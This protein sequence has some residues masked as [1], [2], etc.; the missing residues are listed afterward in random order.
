MS[1]PPDPSTAENPA[2]TAPGEAPGGDASPAVGPDSGDEARDRDSTWFSVLMK[3]QFS[4]AVLLVLA[5]GMVP[6]G[7][8]LAYLADPTLS[9]PMYM[10]QAI[11]TGWAGPL[12]V[13]LLLTSI[14][15]IFTVRG[16]VL[17]RRLIHASSMMVSLVASRA[18]HYQE[19]GVPE[20][21]K[22]AALDAA[23]LI[24]ERIGTAQHGQ[25]IGDALKWYMDN[26]AEAMPAPPARLL[27]K[28]ELLAPHLGRS[29]K[30][31]SGHADE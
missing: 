15:V 22:A 26:V 7:A 2:P 13:F 28:Y 21:A 4:I 24:T 27:R 11:G 6:F 31:P 3:A 5:L 29:K 25:W 12:L 14:K 8:W 20:P 19:V 16:R 1:Q 17:D 18:A 10:M 30:A 9:W 23:A